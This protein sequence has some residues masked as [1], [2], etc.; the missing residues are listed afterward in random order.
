M[1]FLDSCGWKG[2]SGSCE[3]QLASLR[4]LSEGRIRSRSRSTCSGEAARCEPAA[5][6]GA[7]CLTASAQRFDNMLTRFQNENVPQVWNGPILF[8]SPKKRREPAHSYLPI[9]T[10]CG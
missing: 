4:R 10:S 8:S 1:G 5:K 6:G 7:E 2:D 9:R 3:T